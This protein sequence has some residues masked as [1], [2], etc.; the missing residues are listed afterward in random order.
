MNFNRYQ[1]QINIPEIGI[2]GQELLQNAKIL[3]IGAGGLG[4]PGL[5][6][7]AGLGITKKLTLESQ[8]LK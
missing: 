2:K 1:S 8:K 3:V 4:C 7:L 5:I 6:A